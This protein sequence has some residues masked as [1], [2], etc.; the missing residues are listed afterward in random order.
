[1]LEYSL[2][3]AVSIQ[4]SSNTVTSMFDLCDASSC[5]L[6]FWYL[7]ES[8]GMMLSFLHCVRI[9]QMIWT[10][11]CL[12]QDR[13]MHSRLAHTVSVPSALCAV[14]RCHS[15]TVT[16][17]CHDACFSTSKY[18][19]DESCSYMRC[20]LVCVKLQRSIVAAL[21]Y[22]SR[23]SCHNC[24]QSRGRIRLRLLQ[25]HK[26]WGSHKACRAGSA[27]AQVFYRPLNWIFNMSISWIVL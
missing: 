11:P 9:W 19:N 12:Q 18:T 4:S 3:F 16:Q 22:S 10:I 25:S 27:R 13:M 7:A 8:T 26:A 23:K 14:P 17:T 2:S 5:W 1:M 21:T 20:L 15:I 6:P 24:K